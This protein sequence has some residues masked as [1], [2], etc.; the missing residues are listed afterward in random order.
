M[1]PGSLVVPSVVAKF[2]PVGA[3]VEGSRADIL[4]GRAPRLASLLRLVAQNVQYTTRPERRLEVSCNS[5]LHEMYRLRNCAVQ[6]GPSYF[7]SSSLYVEI[8]FALG[9]C[10][11]IVC[12]LPLRF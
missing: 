1:S 12:R 7:L 5:W 4:R 9:S 8:L 10:S 11:P 6:H 3:S 2:F